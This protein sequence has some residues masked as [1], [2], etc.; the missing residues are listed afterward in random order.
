LLRTKGAQASA[1]I[2]EIIN[3]ADGVFLWVQLATKSLI[4]G[5]SNH[6]TILDLRKRLKQVPTELVGL[7]E[8]M[9]NSIDPFYQI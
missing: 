1:L 7:Y 9:L 8:H 4:D 3:V 5:M 6:D 2:D